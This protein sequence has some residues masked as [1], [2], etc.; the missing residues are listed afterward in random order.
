MEDFLKTHFSTSLLTEIDISDIKT[1]ITR[2]CPNYLLILPPKLQEY[3]IDVSKSFTDSLYGELATDIILNE[4]KTMELTRFHRERL[5]SHLISVGIISYWLVDTNQ[6][7]MA[8]RIT[9]YD[10]FFS[11]FLHDIGKPFAKK[12]GKKHGI[13]TGHAQVGSSFMK[14]NYS[15][16]SFTAT[17]DDIC[18]VIDNHM[19]SYAHCGEYKNSGKQFSP[20]L[21]LGLQSTGTIAIDLLSILFI[22][23]Q[24]ARISDI[25]E[26]TIEETIEHAIGWNK[27]MTEVHNWPLNEKVTKICNLKQINNERITIM[28]FGMSGCGK[29]FSSQKIQEFLSMNGIKTEIVERDNS[30]V[31]VYQKHNPTSDISCIP[32]NEIYKF[33]REM[34]T[35]K[36]EHQEQWVNDLNDALEDSEN[37]VVIIDSVQL[38]FPMAWSNTLDGLSEEARSSLYQSL[39]IAYYGFPQHLFGHTYEPKTGSYVSYPIECEG[40]SWPNL[41]TEKGSYSPYEIDY[42][43]GNYES[44]KEMCRKW[45]EPNIIPS[46][47]PQVNL[48]QL[49]IGKCGG[50]LD[51]VSKLFPPNVI[52]QNVELVADIYKPPEVIDSEKKWLGHKKISLHRFVYQDGMQIFT[53]ETRDYRGEAIITVEYRDDEGKKREIYYGRAGLPVFPDMCRISM[54]PKAFPYLI[55]IWEQSGLRSSW[56][57]K[58]LVDGVKKDY[59][60]RVTPKFD[61]SLFNLL[62]IPKTIDSFQYFNVLK[63]KALE[64]SYKEHPNGLFILGSKGTIFAKN[65]VLQRCYNALDG[66]YGNIDKFLEES[67]NWL[68]GSGLESKQTTLHFEA[69]DAIPTVEL[70]VYYGYAMCP[71]LGYTVLTETIGELGRNYEKSF[72]LVDSG[73][74]EYLGVRTPIHDFS[75]WIEAKEFMGKEYMSLLHGSQT[76]EPEGYVVH[77]YDSENN[78]VVS[79]KDKFQI[80]FT[81]HKPNSRS[82]IEHAKEI[83]NSDEFALVRERL[84]KFR[85]KPPIR[86]LVEEEVSWFVDICKWN[87]ETFSSQKDVAIYWNKLENRARLSEKE[88]VIN[89]KIMEHYTHLND[90]CINKGFGV[91]MKVYSGSVSDPEAIWT[92]MAKLFNWE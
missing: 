16:Y 63:T 86:S 22:S 58:F 20:L 1:I 78:H 80:Y 45:L 84:A 10:A 11:G 30:L 23:D 3:L 24:L 41:A 39:K 79:V 81:A 35:G 54:D 44:I 56:K 34:D 77:I 47:P 90:K 65:P 57:E 69:I 29:S 9:T 38:L 5:L 14:R 85:A 17:D 27:L 4:H 92:F 71:F 68:V 37:K 76:V 25:M 50:Q 49:I 21:S 53:G 36:I 28:N 13:Y 59:K 7:P 62:W 2:I 67:Y 26:A 55:D 8:E 32:Y 31:K 40:F 72:H 46:C 74:S 89:T 51:M 33:V 15:K 83:M 52:Q 61:G 75:N 64:G 48:F 82:H 42:G 73:S 66:S 60:L 18:W 91:L 87:K 12:Q 88:K 70:T 43:T 6:V 19:C